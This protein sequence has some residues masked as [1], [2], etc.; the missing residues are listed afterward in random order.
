MTVQNIPQNCSVRLIRMGRVLYFHVYFTCFQVFLLPMPLVVF[1]RYTNMYPMHWARFYC[2]FLF[3]ILFCFSW[4]PRTT[5]VAMA[6]W[7]VAMAWQMWCVRHNMVSPTWTPHPEGAGSTTLNWVAKALNWKFAFGFSKSDWSCRRSVVGPQ[8][9]ET[10]CSGS[11]G[12]WSTRKF[13]F[14]EAEH[15]AYMKM[16]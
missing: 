3:N 6:S 4:R 5:R 12:C 10:V 2:F 14:L 11:E 15:C 9:L 1:H 13:H 7:L 16:I 8:R